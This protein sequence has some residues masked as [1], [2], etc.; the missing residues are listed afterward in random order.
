MLD[1]LFELI[2]RGQESPYQLKGMPKPVES[3]AEAS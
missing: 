2:Q 1:E 3:N